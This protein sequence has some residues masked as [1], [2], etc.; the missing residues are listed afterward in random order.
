M[1]KSEVGG[2]NKKGHERMRNGK[3][4][5]RKERKVGMNE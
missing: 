1:N 5:G 3:I 4:E 2:K